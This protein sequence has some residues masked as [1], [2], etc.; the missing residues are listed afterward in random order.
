MNASEYPFRQC[1]KCQGLGE[2]PEPEVLEDGFGTVVYPKY[3]PKKE[4]PE[5]T[6]SKQG[7]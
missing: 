7:L 5:K 1:M 3:C 6:D 2:C 4:N